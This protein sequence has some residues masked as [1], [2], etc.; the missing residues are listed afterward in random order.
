MDFK[1]DTFCYK[2]KEAGE[3]LYYL[4]YGYSLTEFFEK[5]IDLFI[6]LYNWNDLDT[7]NKNFIYK[8]KEI[9]IKYFPT[10][11]VRPI[12]YEYSPLFVKLR[13]IHI[14]FERSDY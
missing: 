13:H 14:L 10:G 6:N 11:G 12:E 3:L 1:F 5:D 7:F 4:L 2:G 9:L 8:H